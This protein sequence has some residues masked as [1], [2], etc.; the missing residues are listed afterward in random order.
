LGG[1]LIFALPW[2]GGSSNNTEGHRKVGGLEGKGRGHSQT[3]W[4]HT[5]TGTTNVTDTA[6]GPGLGLQSQP[7]SAPGQTGVWRERAEKGWRR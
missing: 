3:K 6:E 5:I 1:V 2:G 4:Q 7:P